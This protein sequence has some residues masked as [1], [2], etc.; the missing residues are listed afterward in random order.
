MPQEPPPTNHVRQE[1]NNGRSTLEREHTSGKPSTPYTSSEPLVNARAVEGDCD[2]KYQARD[3]EVRACAVGEA[4][5]FF[6]E[7]GDDHGR[8]VFGRF[9][10]ESAKLGLENVVGIASL[11]CLVLGVVLRVRHDV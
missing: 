7:L 5:E 8:I 10:D 3:A 11:G 2:V 9:G 6:E 1:K 4:S